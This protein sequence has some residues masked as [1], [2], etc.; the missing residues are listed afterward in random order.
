MN[1]LKLKIK[2]K[3]LKEFKESKWAGCACDICLSKLIEITYQY[4]QNEKKN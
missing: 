1:K 3:I 4:F 2:R